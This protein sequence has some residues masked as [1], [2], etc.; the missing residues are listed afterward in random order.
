MIRWYAQLYVICL[1]SK[2]ATKPRD[3]TW[4]RLPEDIFGIHY[5][6]Y[7]KF[8]FDEFKNLYC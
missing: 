8:I 3:V 4:T 2:A 7:F 6:F 5:I 1:E